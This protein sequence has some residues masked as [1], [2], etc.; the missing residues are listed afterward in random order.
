MPQLTDDSA[1]AARLA[2]RGDDPSSALERAEHGLAGYREADP[3]ALA[4]I[5]R[6]PLR[7]L[8]D[9]LEA[10]DRATTARP[11]PTVQQPDPS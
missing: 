4:V 2:L 1:E 7:A 3:R 6:R 11:A 5:L 8:L 10:A 9:E